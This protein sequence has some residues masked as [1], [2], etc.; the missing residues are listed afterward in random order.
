MTNTKQKILNISLKLFNEHGLADV[1]LRAISES[2]TIS[3]GNLQYHFKKREAIIEELYFQL[4]AEMDSLIIEN[5]NNLLHSFFEL[6]S[7]MIRKLYE[8]RFFL[9]DFV[10]ITRNNK[11]IKN[12]YIELS[13]RREEEFLQM[14]SVFVEGGIFQQSDL[15]DEFGNLF[16]RTEVFSNFWFSSKLIHAENLTEK[17]IEEYSLLMSQSIYS[18]LTDLGR[19][20]YKEIFPNQFDN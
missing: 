8:Y 9:L 4:V 16:K 12:H 7:Q 15:N 17:L 3:V 6:S 13:K 19:T 14:V 10:T 2:A 18:Y 1:S 20:Q 11:I 5:S